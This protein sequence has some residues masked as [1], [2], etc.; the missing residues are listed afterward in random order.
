[1][2]IFALRKKKLR[3]VLYNCFADMAVTIANCSKSLAI[4]STSVGGEMQI[5]EV[6]FSFYE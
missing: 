4:G 5:R 6:V 3:V 2:T 1:M